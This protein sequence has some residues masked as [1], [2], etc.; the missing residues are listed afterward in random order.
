MKKKGF[1]LIEL[2]AVIVILAILAL[3][4]SPIISGVISDA[5]KA[6]AE[7]STEGW[8]KAVEYAIV[9]YQFDNNGTLPTGLS[10]ITVEKSGSEI[11]NE[12]AIWSQESGLVTA[13]T[14]ETGGFVCTYSGSTAQCTATAE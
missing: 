2:L 6:S 10:Q 3:I 11:I 12:S 5:K 9:K 1:T 7:R 4:V 13:A 8:V 14:V